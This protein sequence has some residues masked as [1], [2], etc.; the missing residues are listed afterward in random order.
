MTESSHQ[1]SNQQSNPH[2]LILSHAYNQ[3]G[4]AASITITDK[5][6]ALLNAGISVTVI[7][8]RTGKYDKRVD[9]IQCLPIGPSGLRFDLRHIIARRW[10]RGIRYRVTTFLWSVLLFPM[11]VLERVA[12]GLSNHASWTGSAVF[13]GL[14]AIRRKRPTVIYSSGGAAS[15]H[16]AG[17][18]LKQLTGVAWIAEI[19]DP[20][21]ERKNADDDGSSRQSSR[22][23]RYLARIEHR[24]CREADL[25]WWFTEA[26]LDYAR[27]RHPELGHR[28]T[29]I[30]PG[31]LPP[32]IP[33]DTSHEYN[34]RMTL[35]HFG[36]LSNDRSL[37]PLVRALLS[38]VATGSGIPGDIEIV[39]YGADKDE[40]TSQV[41]RAQPQAGITINHQGRVSREQALAAM[42]R[43]DVLLLI[44]SDGELGPETIPSKIY[45]YFWIRRPVFAVTN[46]NPFLDT[47]IQRYDGFVCSEHDETSIIAALTDC[48]Q[49]WQNRTLT[50][51]TQPPVRVDDAVNTVIS[52]VNRIVSSKPG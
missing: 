19:H 34:E 39:L 45:E 4:S 33:T 24:I 43:A 23:S 42:A 35:C 47:M 36:S 6:P 40:L 15:A 7:S 46:R 9:H 5:I 30:L 48:H 38:M 29:V 28:G 1:P 16:H 13:H 50:P 14:R 32:D 26:A 51:H 37:A 2:W 52:A 25:A 49:R 27:K 17:A 12:F 3:D 44:H 20:L 22:N 41:L 11:M 10:G 8:A 31:C 18:I 21:V